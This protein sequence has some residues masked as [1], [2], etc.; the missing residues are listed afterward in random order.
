MNEP[1]DGYSAYAQ[2]KQWRA[3]M[4]LSAL[5]RE[6]FDHEF[7]GVDLAGKALLEIGFGEG[8]VLAWA[9]ERGAIVT[10]VEVNL[11]SREE[12]V[13]AGV[14][15]LEAITDTREGQFDVIVAFDLFEHLEMPELRVHLE[16]CARALR[17]GGLLFMRYPNGQSPLGRHDQYGDGTHKLVLSRPIVDHAAAGLP[18]TTTRYAGAYRV[19]GTGV[20]GVARAARKTAQDI[21]Q[22]ALSAL[23]GKRLIL[24]PVVTQVMRRGINSPPPDR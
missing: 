17:P 18:L 9:K 16:A 2:W 12:A 8:R 11:W 3:F 20:K 1:E 10:G 7:A 15:L 19:T 5:D 23:Y 21:V 14:P 4:Q 13:K 6:Y 22:C 24:A